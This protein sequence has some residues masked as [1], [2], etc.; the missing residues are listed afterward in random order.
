[1]KTNVLNSHVGMTYKP[2]I[3]CHERLQLNSNAKRTLDI[4]DC[5]VPACLLCLI[6]IR[7]CLLV[8]ILNCE[9]FLFLTLVSDCLFTSNCA[10][11]PI[12]NVSTKLQKMGCT[13]KVLLILKFSPCGINRNQ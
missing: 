3:I 9:S 13:N 10:L 11:S 8:R 12:T 5:S 1:M 7:S 2:Q 6:K 4:V